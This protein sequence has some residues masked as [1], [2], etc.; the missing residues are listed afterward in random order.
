MEPTTEPVA[1][2]AGE[3]PTKKKGSKGRPPGIIEHRSGRYQ[4]RLLGAKV[5]GK[6]Y[7]RPIPGLYKEIE[8]A[9]AAQAASMLLFESGGVEAVWPPKETTPAERN[10]RGEV[11][12]P[13]ACSCTVLLLAPNPLLVC[14]C[15]AQRESTSLQHISKRRLKGPRVSRTSPRAS[16]EV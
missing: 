11:R 4:D 16:G 12:R 2:D 14:T 15:R 9:L 6:A 7:Q 1:D 8:D 3:P 10:K 5:D 13:A